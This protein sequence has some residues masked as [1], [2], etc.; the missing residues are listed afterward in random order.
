[1]RELFNFRFRIW[2]RFAKKMSPTFSIGALIIQEAILS[3]EDLKDLVVMQYTGIKDIEGNELYEGDIVSST[4]HSYYG[5]GLGVIQ[6]ENGR[7]IVIHTTEE[8]TSVL[9]RYFVISRSIKKLGNTFETPELLV[10][11]K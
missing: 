1:M 2:S 8:G 11:L 4:P 10:E 5:G 3:I 6:Y 7:F 9:H